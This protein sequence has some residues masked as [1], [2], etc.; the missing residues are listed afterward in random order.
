MKIFLF[1]RIPDIDPATT[2]ALCNEVSDHLPIYMWGRI[3]RRYL[4][5]PA[6]GYH[7]ATSVHADTIDD[8]ISMYRQDLRLQPQDLRR[9]GLVINI[10]LMGRI[11]PARRRWFSVHFLPP[12]PDGNGPDKVVP[13]PLSL[14]DASTDTFTYAD[15]ATLDTLASWIGLSPQELRDACEKR[16]E[17]LLELAQ[18]DADS[19]DMFDAI[20]AFRSPNA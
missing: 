4:Q 16:T 8:V 2:Y 7:I 10:G 13:V 18:L 12:H 6:Q 15:A 5:F 20:S 9:L 3:A 11:Y 19:R 1:T 17:C 14:W